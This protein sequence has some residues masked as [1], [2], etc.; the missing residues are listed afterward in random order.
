MRALF[1]IVAAVL[2]GIM[3]AGLVYLLNSASDRGDRAG[4]RMSSME[5]HC[6]IARCSFQT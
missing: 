6:T 4:R 3:I 2:L 5:A 1:Y